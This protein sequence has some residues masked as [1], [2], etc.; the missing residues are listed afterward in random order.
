ME[1]VILGDISLAVESTGSGEPV[2]FVHGALIADAFLPLLSQESLSGYRL[3][4]YRRRGYE[5]SSPAPADLSVRGQAQDSRALL[6]H[7]GIEKAHVVGHS[8]G[9]AVALQLALD[10]PQSV[11]SLALLEPALMVGESGQGYRDALQNLVRQYEAQ[12][13]VTAVAAMLGARWPAYREGL[14]PVMPG[15]LAQAERDAGAAFERELPS[16][17]EWRFGEAEAARITQPVL[18][19]IGERSAGLSPRFE[20]SHRWLL[21]TLKNVEGYVLPGA[22]H[23]LQVENPGDM[24]AALASFFARHAI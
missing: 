19:V 7:F 24:A 18:S 9:G 1:Q 2:L 6:Q 12:G 4:S 5:G 14:A 8:F 16:L 17:M 15:A 10:S 20:A 21:A 13:V 11:R 23:F 3:I 22:H